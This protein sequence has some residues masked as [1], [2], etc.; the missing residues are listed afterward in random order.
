[1][2]RLMT[3]G[4]EGGSLAAD[5]LISGFFDSGLGGTSYAYSTTTVRSGARALQ[6]KGGDSQNLGLNAGSSTTNTYYMRLALYPTTRDASDWYVIQI[7]DGSTGLQFTVKPTG[8]MEV[9]NYSSNSAV[10]TGVGTLALNT[11]T[12]IE[13]SY[14]PGTGATVVR[15][16]GV[17]VA[18][19]TIETTTGAFCYIANMFGAGVAF[20]DDWAINDSTGA[21]QN[22][23][24]GLGQVVH[25]QPVS[26]NGRI[27]WVAGVS[28][29]TN[30]WD[31]VNN[32]PPVG[33]AQASGTVTSQIEDNANN[34]TDTYVAALQTYTAAGVPAGSTV[35]LAKPYALIGNS[36]T[37]VRQGGVTTTNPTISET[38]QGTPA[39]VA[40]TFPTNWSLLSPSPTM[41]P[42]V[43]L[44]TA[45]TLTLRKATASADYLMCCAMALL[46]EYTAPAVPVVLPLATLRDDFSGTTIDTTKWAL[47]G[48]AGS[49]TEG[50]GV[51]TM[52]VTATYTA[53]GAIAPWQL[54]GSSVVVQITPPPINASNSQQ[55]GISLQIAQGSDA[56]GSIGV[57][58]GG[59]ANNLT[60]FYYDT[61]GIAHFQTQ[62]S[63]P[64][65]PCWVR[66]RESGGTTFWDSSPDG[67]AWTNW[68]SMAN[69]VATA[70]VYPQLWAG[71]FST[72]ADST[73]VFDKFNLP[74][75][76][77]ASAP[78]AAETSTATAPTSKVNAF[79]P[80]A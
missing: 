55:A 56:S 43:T 42:T 4:F 19:G 75:P 41:S 28:G 32:A 20:V 30:L 70:S 52:Q 10:I 37:T 63:L 47:E 54:T 22:S 27:G 61:S 73:A 65:S 67:V 39:A 60:P 78:A 46:V 58:I 48:A 23:W 35:V 66:I 26:D 31:A 21:A 16:N 51:L 69:P 71:H 5:L 17:Q 80:A 11:W 59:S 44:G 1:M 12:V 38:V 68:F 74:P 6:L 25:L 33:V 18:S 79:V 29:T 13:V 3:C 8:A 57:N 9:E 40:G 2:A 36:S 53:V 76:I 72:G 45:P 62:A 64:G 77:V 7:T 34:T 15:V 24:P 14:V 49:V 50:S